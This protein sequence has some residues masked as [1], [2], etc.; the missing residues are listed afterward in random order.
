VTTVL[1]SIFGIV[2]GERPHDSTADSAKEA[3][4]SFM[5]SETASGR[6]SHGS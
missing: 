2:F 3:M 5:A 6:A 1:L 4:A